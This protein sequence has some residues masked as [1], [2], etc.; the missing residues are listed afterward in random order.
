MEDRS[1]KNW[2][3]KRSQES[4]DASALVISDPSCSAV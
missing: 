2:L 3:Q 4:M 1:K